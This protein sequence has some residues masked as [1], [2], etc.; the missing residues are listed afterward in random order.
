MSGATDN[1]A[2]PPLPPV[3][4][5]FISY[6]SE[7]RP[8]ARNLRDALAAAGLEVWYDENELVGGDAW[9]QKL[10][11]Q[12]RDC[13]YFMPV[14]SA[15]TEARKEG[16]FR[17]EWRL[18][19]ERTLDMADDVLFLLPVAIDDTDEL[20]ARVPDKFRTV[21]WLR[22]P[23]GKPTPMLQTVMERLRAG[24]HHTL[25]RQ[26]A[27]ATRA[28]FATQRTTA[29]FGPPPLIPPVVPP[30]LAAEPP[31]SD[32]VPPPRMPPFPHVPEKN[33]IFHGIKFLAE[34]FWWLLTVAWTLFN[35]LPKWGR[36]VV[37][38]W[39]VI[40]LF[41]IRFS[42]PPEKPA[43][44]PASRTPSLERGPDGAKKMR[45]VAERILQ[46]ARE[47]RINLGADDLA[48]VATE[49]AH[50]F[51]EGVAEP[52]A[53]GKPLLI[54][55]FAPPSTED[56]TGKL[57]HAVFISVY[58]RLALERRNDVGVSAP[59]KGEVNLTTLTTRAAALGSSFV[60]SAT[61]PGDQ[62]D[63]ALTVQLV[64]V[65]DRQVAWT[66]TFPAANAEP[67]DIAETISNKVLALVP[68]RESRRAKGESPK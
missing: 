68:R 2:S 4:T 20:Y 48:K 12:I 24:D 46:S 15:N 8:A 53:S 57:A 17:R 25:P 64:T 55:P 34:V 56:P 66:E 32:A 6:A 22:V 18:A 37:T 41:S 36:V 35:R 30:V 38:V 27:G 31:V 59:P 54:I 61:Y 29:P 14:I 50:V 40:T 5:V 26:P 65:A 19:T 49:I 63:P 43:P 42:N 60:L 51:G 23:E 28:P 47:G 13:E 21:Q 58:G 39:L 7:D 44:A 1:D 10:R 52:P 62:A 45:P 3:P 9:D 33:G 67:T 16:Y 11:R